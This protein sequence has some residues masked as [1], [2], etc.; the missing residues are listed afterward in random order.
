MTPLSLCP[1][2]L[3]FPHPLLLACAAHD[4]AAML[5]ALQPNPQKTVR[6]AYENK[7][8]RSVEKVRG[9][10]LDMLFTEL[11]AALFK[12]ESQVAPLLQMIDAAAVIGARNP[13]F[14]Q[15]IMSSLVRASSGRLQDPSAFLSLLQATGVDWR[16]TVTTQVGPGRAE[17]E[18]LA[19]A[20]RDRA[21]ALIHEW[22]GPANASRQRSAQR[23]R[24]MEY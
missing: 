12:E 13:D 6:F 17:E 8:S 1:E 2:E 15:T 14:Q 20:L 7:A 10:V 16:R 19:N 9:T 18:S 24:R 11:E 22:A 23:R 21:P 3:F 4:Q 5:T